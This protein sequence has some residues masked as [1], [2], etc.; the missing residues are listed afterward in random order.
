[1]SPVWA[2]EWS[3]VH[4]A[5]STPDSK[6]W[7]CVTR[8]PVCNDSVSREACPPPAQHRRRRCPW[9]PPHPLLV[10]EP[11]EHRAVLSEAGQAQPTSSQSG[12]SGLDRETFRSSRPGLSRRRAANPTLRPSSS[13]SECH[14]VASP[15]L[16][17]ELCVQRHGHAQLPTL[18]AGECPC[19]S[20]GR[21]VSPSK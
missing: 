19:A 20:H 21:L 17:S 2:T 3:Q 4:G 13:D 5:L 15:G 6:P 7:A 16:P 9:K 8:V 18:R 12:R 1:M 14:T 10:S 11:A